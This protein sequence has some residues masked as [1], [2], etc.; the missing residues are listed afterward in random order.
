M[1][2]EQEIREREEATER[3]SQD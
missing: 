1:K 2:E 3:E